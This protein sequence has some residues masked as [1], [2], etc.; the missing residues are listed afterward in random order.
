MRFVSSFLPSV[1]LEA[2]SKQACRLM[3]STKKKTRVLKRDHKIKKNRAKWGP[4]L[5]DL[6]EGIPSHT[7]WSM[8]PKEGA[9]AGD[10]PMGSGPRNQSPGLSSVMI[11]QMLCFPQPSTSPTDAP[12]HTSYS[13]MH[14]HFLILSQPPV[15]R[16]CPEFISS[17]NKGREVGL[18]PFLS[19]SPCPEYFGK[20]SKQQQRKFAIRLC[21]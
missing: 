21:H 1:V 8:T 7:R 5:V 2:T 14:P 10:C 4:V 6:G 15:G 17:G 20:T 3:G 18:H 11:P 12:S 19:L 9:S 16:K 13:R